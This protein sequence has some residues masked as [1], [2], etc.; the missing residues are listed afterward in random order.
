MLWIRERKWRSSSS[1]V[2]LY[3]HGLCK[4]WKVPWDRVIPEKHWYF[5]DWVPEF[6][7]LH[8]NKE[9]SVSNSAPT[10]RNWNALNNFVISSLSLITLIFFL[11]ILHLPKITRDPKWKDCL[12]WTKFSHQRLYHNPALPFHSLV[13]PYSLECKG[14]GSIYIPCGGRINLQTLLHL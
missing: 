1:A 12:R 14:C 10:V 5:P 13:Y 2:E 11:H 4:R 7:L 6:H 8:R 9:Y 3:P